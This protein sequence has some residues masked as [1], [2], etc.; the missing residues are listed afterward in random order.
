MLF[1]NWILNWLIHFF[2][3][4]F[5]YRIVI[6]KSLW[7]TGIIFSKFKLFQNISCVYTHSINIHINLFVKCIIYFQNAYRIK[8]SN[9]IK[10]LCL[11]PFQKKKRNININTFSI[12]T[13]KH[14]KTRMPVYKYNEVI[15]FIWIYIFSRALY[16]LSNSKHT[17]KIKSK[18]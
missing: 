10:H 1:L 16:P 12:F 3:S 4:H 6:I 15:K 2:H 9:S 11:F 7:M 18:C 8:Y 17:S 13:Y 5:I 14:F